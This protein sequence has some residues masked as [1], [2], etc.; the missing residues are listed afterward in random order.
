MRTLVLALLLAVSGSVAAFAQQE[1]KDPSYYSERAYQWRADH[2]NQA[3]DARRSDDRR[4]AERWREQQAYERG[5]QEADR[6]QQNGQND[7]VNS[8]GRM[9]NNR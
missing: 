3:Y 6:N 9:F 2:P 1:P 8:I 7:I 4:D 5:R